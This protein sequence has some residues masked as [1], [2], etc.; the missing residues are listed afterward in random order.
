MRR[1]S[2]LIPAV[3]LVGHA[4]SAQ[5]FESG[6]TGVDGPFMPT[7]NVTVTLP[8]D[9]VLNYTIFNVPSGITVTFKRNKANT[10]VHVLASDTVVI[11]GV[12]NV[13][14]GNPVATTAIAGL[15]ILGGIGGPGG[16]DG[17]SMGQLGHAAGLG[18]GGGIGPEVT[19]GKKSDCPTAG[20]GASL[21]NDGVTALAGYPGQC[22]V[23]AGGKAYG[24][25]GYQPLHGGS[26][27]GSVGVN[28]GG[29]GGGGVIV[30]ASSK[31]ITVNGTI[32]ARG[33]NGAHSGA[34]GGGGAG[35]GGVIRLAA[36]EIHGKGTLDARTG[37]YCSAS[38]ENYWGACGGNGLIRVEGFDVDLTL[39]P[40]AKPGL[41]YAFPLKAVPYPL[42]ERPQL[43]VIGV[44]GKTPYLA[45]NFGHAHQVPGLSLP[46]GKDIAVTV[47][48]A[49]VPLG[50]KVNVIVNTLGHGQL[51]ATTDGLAGAIEKSTASATINIPTGTRMGTIEAWIPSVPLN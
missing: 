6:S 31:S 34:Y 30:I 1:F 26:G 4:A 17:A 38:N 32:L 14:G 28:T 39:E 12:I 35:G 21:V 43:A 7:K 3:L 2:L 37:D 24:D 27:G 46:T 42:I 8:D 25:S 10:A 44:A 50:T 13:S 15:T 33:G 19:A 45:P 29:G 22:D 48:A 18:P 49:W 5:I 51:L 16:S 20:G 9:G 36:P 11:D 47:E 41:Q 40:N 23:G